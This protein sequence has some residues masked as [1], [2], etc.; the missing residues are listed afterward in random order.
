MLKKIIRKIFWGFL[1]HIV[2]DRKYA[3]IRFWLE[4][5]RLPDLENPKTFNEKIQYIKLYRRN[6]LRK[7]FA[8][9]I[10]ARSYIASET[11]EKHLIPL[12]GIYDRLSEEE[13]EK[14]PSQ[15]VLKA[16]HGCG[17][18]KIIQNKDNHDFKDIL[19]TIDKWQKTDYYKIGREW[20]YKNLPRS[21]VIEKLLRNEKG[22]IPEDYKFFCF[23]GTVEIIQV[24]FGRFANQ[25]RNLY[26]R[27]FNLLPAR[28]IYENY[29]GKVSRPNNLGKAIEISEKLSAGVSFL[30]VDMY[31]I[32][33]ELYVGE[34]T[35]YPGNG[36]AKIIPPSF[37]RT[38]G[39]KLHLDPA[40]EG[41]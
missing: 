38:L 36:F 41:K 8:S 7:T 30:R 21:L 3:Q 4:F 28:I 25:K 18:V 27:D 24:D 31:L 33:E 40:I 2:T 15:F 35:N 6:D 29:T 17:M 12:I 16:N 26:D 37:D 34:L 20:V 22:D 14:L 9:R 10:R 32:G 19:Q 39:N 13:W 23:N 5:D 11:D 1:R